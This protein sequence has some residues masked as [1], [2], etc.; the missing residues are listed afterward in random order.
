LQEKNDITQ[1]NNT[2]IKIRF[3]PFFFN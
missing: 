2:G 3:M 1:T